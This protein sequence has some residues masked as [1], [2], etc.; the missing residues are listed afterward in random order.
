MRRLGRTDVD[1]PILSFGAGPVSGLMHSTDTALQRVTI[2]AA[3]EIGIDWFDVA[4]TYGDGRAETNLGERL[5]ELG[6]GASV[7]IATK[8]RIEPDSASSVAEQIE[9][10]VAESLRRL[11]V[12][13]IALLQIHNAI[14]ER[15]GEVA[16]AIE[17]HHVLDDAKGILPTLIRLRERGMVQ[18]LGL[19]GIGSAAAICE[20]LASGEF[21]SV[22]TPL[23][24]LNPS[25]VRTMAGNFAET[26]HQ[27]LMLRCRELG[28]G[29]FAIRVFAGGALAGKQPSEHTFKTKYFPLD[30]YRRDCANAARLRN[31]LPP[32]LSL[33][34]MALRFAAFHPT[35][36]SA[37]VGFG[38][39]KEVGDAASWAT[40]GPLPGEVDDMLNRFWGNLP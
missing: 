15:A 31:L 26:D 13:S 29:G 25:N 10:T 38:S 3:L 1:V 35:V 12:P 28:V 6:V 4:P 22:Q 21:V 14:A 33:E 39:A 37:I 32:E 9:R 16:S 36:A 24:L 23:N 20:V 27:Q 40:A 7:R 34:E 2:A 5:R 17:P 11:Q 8:V 19:T 30:L 18:H